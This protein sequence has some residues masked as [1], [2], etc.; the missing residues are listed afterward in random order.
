ME[1][2]HSFF[3]LKSIGG[4]HLYLSHL[5]VFL[6]NWGLVF[7]VGPLEVHWPTGIFWIWFCF[8][9]LEQE[10]QKLISKR[11]ELL[12][13][14]LLFTHLLWLVLHSHFCLCGVGTEGSE[15][16]A[17]SLRVLHF[18]LLSLPPAAP[19]PVLRDEL[20]S[21]PGTVKDTLLSLARVT[22]RCTNGDTGC[23]SCGEFPTKRCSFLCWSCRRWEVGTASPTKW[24]IFTDPCRQNFVK[25]SRTAFCFDRKHY[26]E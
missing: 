16:R 17:C 15:A 23:T 22:E 10:S 26:Y 8:S 12:L 14:I 6:W 5:A 1:S 19:G 13:F 20:P 3:L 24:T 4:R 25:W 18:V 21:P 9:A 2:Q 11:H 7:D